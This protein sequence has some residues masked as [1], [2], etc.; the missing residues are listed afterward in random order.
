VVSDVVAELRGQVER[1]ADQGIAASSLI[2][3][4][5][6][7]YA[8][9]GEHNWQ[10]LHNIRA[11]DALGLPLLV[12]VSRKRFLG[13]LLAD[14]DGTPR[15]PLGRDHATAALSTVLALAGV[16]CVRVHAVR[17]NRDAVAVV[18]RLRAVG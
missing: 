6:F 14:P 11:F 9:T 2:V 8:K 5:G 1:A 16:W 12:G 18:N 13:S 4:P 3:D 7:G 10:L 17:E 15:P